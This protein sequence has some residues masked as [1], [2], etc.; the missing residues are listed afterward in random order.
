MTA[1]EYLRSPIEGTPTEL[2][3]GKV[4]ALNPPG[5]R[6]GQ[7]CS[8]IA[9]LLQRHLEEQPCGWVVS[10]DSGVITERD[11]DT[12][13]G[14]DVAFYSYETIPRDNPPK[15]YP[16]GPPELIFEVL[17]PNDRP[18]EIERKVKEYLNAGV[19]GVYVVDDT[20]GVVNKFELNS[21][22]RSFSAKESITF[23][24]Q[25]FSFQTIAAEIFG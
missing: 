20:R 10:N 7:I 4:V 18:A 14:A 16:S 5:F 22:V 15:G 21:D 17:S 11:P 12:V 3:Q 24:G 6:H 25:L 8:R 23:P 13:R 19:K 2:V 1:E 9:Y